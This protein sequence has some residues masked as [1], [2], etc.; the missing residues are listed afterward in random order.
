MDPVIKTIK[1]DFDRFYD[2]LIK[3][4]DVCPDDVWISKE[5]GYF[6]WQQ[7]LHNICVTEMFSVKDG[8]SFK[9]KYSMP[10]IMLSEEQLDHINKDELKA[11]ALEVREKACDYFNSLKPEK[12]LE[13]H[14]VFTET[15][16]RETNYLSVLISIVRH[17]TY[18]IGCLDTVLRNHGVKGVY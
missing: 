17:L 3:Q 7:I 5:G 9:P 14:P 11:L 15:M 1:D 18:H 2:M 6:Y 13:V 10:V 8:D 4:I 16:K 12:L